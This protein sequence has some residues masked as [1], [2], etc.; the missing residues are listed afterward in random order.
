MTRFDRHPAR[1]ERDLVEEVVAAGLRDSE[2]EAHD[3]QAAFVGN[4]AAGLLS[5]QESVRAQVVLRRTGLMGVPMVNVENACA[6]SSTALHLGWQAVAGGIHDRVVV[7]GYE[8]LCH[9]DRAA[10]FRAINASLDLTE[11]AELFGEGAERD[12]RSVF[13]DL[14]GL[15]S[16][17]RGRDRFDAETLALVAVKNHRHGS[18]NPCAHYRQ[19]VTLEQVLGARRIVGPLTV[20]MCTPLSDGAACL[21]LDA[22]EGRREGRGV[23]IAASV[24]TSGRGD[25]LTRSIG[26][27]RAAREAFSAA[28]VGPEDLDVVEVHDATAVGE[29]LAYESLGFCGR[30]EGTRLLRDRETWLGGRLPVNPSGGLLARG[31]PIGATGAAQVVELVWQLQGRCGARQVPDAKLALAHNVGGWIGSDA[32]A[33]CIHILQA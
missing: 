18:L 21:V 32:A 14:Y 10:S 12:E 17:G 7:V 6:S 16:D 8:K 4:A 5:G 24:L 29:L 33:C 9:P 3:V 26:A 11:L 22:G 27:Q 25:D 2:M 1:S 19:E 20:L 15:A 31:H 30:G 28:G 13:M 23:R